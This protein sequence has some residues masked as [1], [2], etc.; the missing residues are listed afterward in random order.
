VTSSRHLLAVPA[1]VR[2]VG[3]LLAR[4]LLGAILM[5]HGWQKI[6][7]NGLGATGDAFEGMGI[8]LAHASAVF[9]GVVELVGGALIVLGL[10]TTIAGLLNAVNLFGAFWF[11]HRGHGVFATDGGWELVAALGLASLV[12]VL[13]GPGRYS[14]DA[15]LTGRRATTPA[16]RTTQNDRPS[17]STTAASGRSVAE[18][19]AATR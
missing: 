4:V 12:F 17:S 2:E 16:A 10:L 11:V 8:P 9:A 19:P 18:N 15:L 6:A 7:T 3:L 5:A 14:L 13:V 1:P